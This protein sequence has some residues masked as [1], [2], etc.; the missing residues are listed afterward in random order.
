VSAWRT[1]AVGSL[2]RVVWASSWRRL[3]HGDCS[4]DGGIRISISALL[5]ASFFRIVVAAQRISILRPYGDCGIQRP[6]V[7]GNDMT[8]AFSVA[9]RRRGSGVFQ[10]VAMI[11]YCR[12]VLCVLCGETR[13][14]IGSAQRVVADSLW[15]ASCDLCLGYLSVNSTCD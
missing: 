6:G 8:A 13:L 5:S 15:P 2:C 14:F 7:G 10:Y 11:W 3:V 4:A 1:A 9:R 12:P